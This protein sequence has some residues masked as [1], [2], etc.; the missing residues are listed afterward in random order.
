MTYRFTSSLPYLLNRV[1]VRMGELFSQRLAEHDLTLPMYRVMAV[2]RQEGP[3]RLGDLSAM[4]TVEI[5]TLSRL[6]TAMKQVGLVSRVRPEDNGRT[7]RIDLTKAGEKLVDDLM[8]IAAHF[9]EVSIKSF[10]EDEVNRI[11][12]ALKQIHENLEQIG[13]SD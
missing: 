8:P 4:V 6:V 10:S 13:D 5:S 9:E 7:V 1:G 11:K 3:Q 12:N 2:L